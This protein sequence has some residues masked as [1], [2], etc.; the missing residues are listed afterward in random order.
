[1]IWVSGLGWRVYD[2]EN[3]WIGFRR[4]ENRLNS[5]APIVRWGKVCPQWKPLIEK[6]P[7]LP[8]SR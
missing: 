8:F 3:M 4:V 7:L 2:D 5:G 1:M 6:M